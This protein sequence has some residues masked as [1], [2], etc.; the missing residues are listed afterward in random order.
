MVYFFVVV[1]L[2]HHTDDHHYN[3]KDDQQEEEKKDVTDANEDMDDDEDDV[4]K[5]GYLMKQSLHIKKFRKRFIILRD[6]HL[7]C[8]TNHKKINITEVINLELF[9]KAEITENEIAEF[10]LLPKIKK[11]KKRKFSAESMDDADAWINAI[12]YSIDPAKQDQNN[13]KKEVQGMNL[14]FI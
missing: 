6:N 10:K 13:N 1:Q 2:I 9:E 5:E 4:T 12:N 7:F 11:N 8:Y 3:N 14:S